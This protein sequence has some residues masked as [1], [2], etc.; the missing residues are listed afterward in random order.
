MLTLRGVH[1]GYGRSRVLHGVDLTVPPD[2]VAAVLG[3]NGAGKTHPAAG[4]GRACCARAPAPSSWTARTSPALGPHERVARGMA[5]VPQG[6]QCFPQLTAAENLQL[7]ADG[8]RDG[9][10]ATAEVLDLFPALRPLLR[11][12]AGLLSGGQRQQ[13]AIARALITRPRL[14]MLDEPTEG[15]Q[16]SVVAE[17]QE[18]IVELTRQSGFS[19]LLVEQH[20]GFALRVAEPL[21]RAGVRSGHLARRRWCHCGAGGPGG[22]GRL[23]SGSVVAGQVVGAGPVESRTTSRCP[24]GRRRG[25]VERGLRAR[26]SAV[27]PISVIGRRMVVRLGARSAATET[28][29]KPTTD[30]RA[31][32]GTRRDRNVDSTPMAIASLSAMIAVVAGCSLRICSAAARPPP[33]VKSLCTTA[34]SAGDRPRCRRADD[35]PASRSATVVRPGAARGDRDPLMAEIHQVLGERVTAGLVVRQDGV[36]AERVPSDGGG[37]SAVVLERGQLGAGRGLHPGVVVAGTADQD[38]ADPLGDQVAQLLQLVAG[39]AAGLAD[40]HQQPLLGGELDDPGGDLGEVRVVDLVDDQPHGGAGPAGQGAGVRVGDV[41][42]LT[43]DLPDPVGH[44]GA[45]PLTAGEGAGGGRQRDGG[46]FGDVHEARPLV[47]PGH[48]QPSGNIHVTRSIAS[49][50]RSKPRVR[51][52]LRKRLRDRHQACRETR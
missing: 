4:R 40:L 26:V 33:R 10:V 49:A 18:R 45:D 25:R 42:Q 9:A 27:R 17:I 13:L 28:S 32:T 16:P 14:L 12:R 11:R 19:V 48:P 41:A 23:T 2:G 31:G 37:P 35:T 51:K 6:Q 52:R 36:D 5:Y 29:S 47:G 1:A 30:I 46:V 21:P 50:I 24:V 15:I 44:L 43:G 38:D 8:R 20:L 22:P 3:H 39:V 7:V 34:R